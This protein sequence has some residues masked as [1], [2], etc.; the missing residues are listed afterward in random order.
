MSYLFS[1]GLSCDPLSQENLPLVID[2]DASVSM[3]MFN[4]LKLSTN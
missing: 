2:T 4:V 1:V 3:C